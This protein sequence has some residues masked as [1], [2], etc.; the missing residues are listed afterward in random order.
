MK[1]GDGRECHF[2]GRGTLIIVAARQSGRNFDCRACRGPPGATGLVVGF[3]A[4][5]AIDVHFEDR[6]MMHEAIYGGQLHGGI[7][8]DLAPFVEGL[9]GGDQ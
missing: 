9:V 7:E 1:A 3:L 2:D 6:G 4:S 8:E 5:I